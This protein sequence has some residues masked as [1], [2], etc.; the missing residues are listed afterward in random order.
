M[1][2][3]SSILATVAFGAFVTSASAAQIQGIFS[4]YAGD[5]KVVHKTLGIE[6]K[7]EKM[8]TDLVWS[9]GAEFL[10]NPVGPLMV[11][12]GFGYMSEQKKDFQYM[13]ATVPVWASIGVKFGMDQ[14][15]VQ[16]Y[17]GARVGFPV[18]ASSGKSWYEK[19]SDV[20]VTGN[21]G[22]QFPFH[23]GLEFDCT[24]MTMYQSF[25]DQGINMRSTAIKVGGSLTVHFDLFKDN[26][27]VAE[28][29]VE[30]TAEN[31]AAEFATADTTSEAPVDTVS[32]EAPVE[33]QPAEQP[34]EEQPVEEPVAEQPAEEPVAESTE[35]VNDHAEE[36]FEEP[37][38]AP[39]EEETSIEPTKK[40]K[41]KSK[42]DKKKKDKKKKDK[43]KDKK[44]SKKD[45]KSKKKKK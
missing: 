3:I 34:V 25:K 15:T 2:K 28:Q 20:F 39:A 33:E 22:V 1:K 41:K 4:G 13:P 44:K 11:G 23:V 29:P 26:N 6:D 24:Y 16:P 7:N 5:T 10:V 31:L 32:A 9:V 37:A 42:K 40:D 18:P 35:A 30:E 45:K 36:T 12:G 38:A 17:L 14:W 8:K 27:K 21:V 43:K 19:P